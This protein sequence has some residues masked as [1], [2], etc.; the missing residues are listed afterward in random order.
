MTEVVRAPSHTPPAD[1]RSRATVA[2]EAEGAGGTTEA[3]LDVAPEKAASAIAAPAGASASSWRCPE[4]LT[5]FRR[6]QA[7]QL[8]C[9]R[10]HKRTYNNRWLT[11]GAVLAPLYATARVT[12]FGTRGDEATG[13]RAGSDANYLIQRWREEDKAANRM[14]AEQY[15][16]ER[17]RLGLVDVVR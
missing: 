15:M 4:C 14:P 13:R 16:A 5:A 6:S 7:T 2:A 1:L 12:R 3:V 8:F 9:C 11:R 17:Y 10:E